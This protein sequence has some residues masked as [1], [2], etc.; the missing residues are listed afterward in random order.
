MYVSIPYRHLINRAI[1]F[2]I[3]ANVVKLQSLIGTLINVFKVM[4]DMQMQKVSFNP[5]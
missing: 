5:L 2:S 3:R 1:S 4:Q